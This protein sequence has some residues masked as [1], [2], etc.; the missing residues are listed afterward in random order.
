[1]WPTAGFREMEPAM[2]GLDPMKLQAAIEFETPTSNRQA[3]VVVRHGYVAAEQYFGG[4]S[5]SSRHESYSMAKSFSAA[6]VGIAIGAGLIEGVDEK[7]CQYYPED[8]DC[9]DTSD[10]RSRITIAH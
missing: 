10:P 1:Y 6:L 4:F 5:A 7:L 8:W 3:V 9:A 2:L